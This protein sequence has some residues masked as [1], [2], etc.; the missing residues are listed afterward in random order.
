MKRHMRIFGMFSQDV[1]TGLQMLFYVCTERRFYRPQNDYHD[2]ASKF[3][4]EDQFEV[5]KGPK[6]KMQFNCAF[7]SPYFTEMINP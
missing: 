7:K 3:M 2:K 6:L 5:R 1:Y 4:S